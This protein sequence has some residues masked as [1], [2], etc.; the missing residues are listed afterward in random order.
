MTKEE[1]SL[2][3]Q[4]QGILPLFYHDD[5]ETCTGVIDALYS[6][7]IRAVEFTN[8]GTL[9]LQNFTQLAANG[10]NTMAGL[11]AWHWHRDDHCRR[12]LL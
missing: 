12:I 5:I 6:T 10:F 3:I 7:G 4:Q 9:A 11:A 8:R 1:I 2:L